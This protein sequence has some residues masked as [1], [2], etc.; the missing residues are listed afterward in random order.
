F[1]VVRGATHS[2]LESLVCG[3]APSGAKL[4]DLIGQALYS[5][6][7]GSS[8]GCAPVTRRN[9]TFDSRRKQMSEK[10]P[11]A[12]ETETNVARP[13]S[14]SQQDFGAL[15]ARHR[16]YFRSGATR[17]VEWRERP[18]IALRSLMKDRAEGFYAP[19]LA[20]LRRNRIDAESTYGKYIYSAA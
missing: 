20:D 17:P 7:G 11:A 8:L 6:P 2:S 12:N 4:R 9:L 1:H 19:L 13:S 15:V 5:F 16:N 14:S 3:D 10:K 18:L